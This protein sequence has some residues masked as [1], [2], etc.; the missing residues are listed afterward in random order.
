M[1]EEKKRFERFQMFTTWFFV[2]WVIYQGIRLIQDEPKRP[3]CEELHRLHEIAVRLQQELG[4]MPNLPDS[5]RVEASTLELVS[6]TDE[7]DCHR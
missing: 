6:L 3:T 2:F 1:S 4:Q 7:Y 5:Q